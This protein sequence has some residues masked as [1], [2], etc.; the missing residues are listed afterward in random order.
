VALAD[1]HGAAIDAQLPKATR[2]AGTVQ[3]WWPAVLIALLTVVDNARTEGFAIIKQVKNRLRVPQHD[4]QPAAYPH[5]YRGD[6]TA[7]ISSVKRV[8]PRSSSPTPLRT[9]S[10]RNY[11]AAF[12]EDNRA[13]LRECISDGRRLRLFSD[14]PGCCK[15]CLSQ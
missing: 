1:S 12:D 6:P 9:E 4:Q 8:T 11:D 15:T 13:V 7:K 3:T 2:P 5:P 10:G 14:R